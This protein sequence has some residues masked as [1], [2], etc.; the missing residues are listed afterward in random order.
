MGDDC[1]PLPWLKDVK[2]R[3]VEEDYKFFDPP[4]VVWEKINGPVWEYGTRQVF[5]ETRDRAF[6]SLEYLSTCRVSELCRADLGAGYKPSV[7]KDQFSVDGD[8]LKFREAIILKRMEKVDGEW[9]H[10]QHLEDYPKRR[11]IPLPLKGGLGKFTQLIVDYL[12]TLDTEEELFK[13]RRGRAHQIVK[14]T[15]GEMNHYLRDMGLKLYSRLLDRNI[16]DLIDFSGHARV[17]NLMKY[18]GEGQLEEKVL[19]Y[20]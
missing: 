10:I 17:Q 15:T 20:A 7:T 14:H 16:K 3:S 19:N 2:R 18:L 9:V 1:V 11:E 12:D 4:R 6:M 8:L 13:F 5:Y